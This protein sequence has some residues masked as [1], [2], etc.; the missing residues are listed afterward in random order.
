MTRTIKN[1]KKSSKGSNTK[2]KHNSKGKHNTKSK[3]NTTS[4]HNAKSKRNEKS[5]RN[6]KGKARKSKG[7]A[8]K[9]FTWKINDCVKPIGMQGGHYKILKDLGTS[10]LMRG[11]NRYEETIPK[12]VE[13]YGWEKINC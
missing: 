12:N 1:V 3:H 11:A 9:Q 4:K 5:K 6:P 2:S 13:F 8:G 10:W 7:V